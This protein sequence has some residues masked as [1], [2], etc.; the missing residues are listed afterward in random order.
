[1]EVKTDTE[2][3]ERQRAMLTR[4]LLVDQPPPDGG[5]QG[6]DDGG[7]R[8]ARPR[9]P[10]RRRPGRSPARPR[11]RRGLLEPRD[12]GQPRRLH[13]LRPLRAGLRRHP[14][15]RRHRPLGQGLWHAHRLRP[16]RPDGRVL[17]RDVRRVR[18]G[19]PDRGPRQQA[20]QRRADQA[21]LGARLG[22]DASARTAGSA[23][24]SPTTSTA[25]ATRSPSP[26]AA[27]SPATAA[28]CASRAATGGTTPPTRSGSRFRS[29]GAR[30]PTPRARCR[31]TCAAR[32]R[33]GASRAGWWTTRRCCR[34][35]ARRRWEE[36]LD[37]AAGRLKAIH[38]EHGPGAIAG[39]GSAKCSNEE[40]YLFQKL[41]RAGFGTNNV[42]H[43]TRLCHASSVAALFEGVGSGAVSTTYGDIV[44]AEVAIMAGTNTTA[45]HPVASSFFKQARRRGTKLIVVDPRRER[46]AD[47]A[48]IFCQI[49]PGTDVA[50]YNGV[51]HEIIKLGLV[52]REFIAAA[53]DELRRAG[54][55][56]Q[57]VPA[58]ARGADLRGRRRRHPHRREAVGRGEHGD[59]LLG[60]G[61]LAAHDRHRQRP[62]PDR[63]V[64]DH[65][66][67]WPAG[68]RPA[69]AARPEQRPGGLGRRADP[70][71]VPGLSARGPGGGPRDLPGARGA[72]SSIPTA[73]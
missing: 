13:P 20:D 56:G 63:A 26:R 32:A 52:D 55:D 28:G 46:I 16:E 65:R 30:A 53:D 72:A 31:A 47:H 69:P 12:R 67:G 22:R 24:R 60:H 54:Q 2:Q 35:S 9:A 71:D 57:G 48:D 18:R 4:L 58:G 70:D 43:C 8:A 66:P 50:F 61:D 23:A 21:A 3:V 51:M 36:A 44:N 29:S 49:K 19:L 27:S 62:L 40:A 14:G 59:R 17:V 33:G 6:D 68:H 25:S 1:M 34:T 45:N 38:S 10:L 42:D 37:L 39:F 41:I 7:Q 15:Q 73:G 64:L 11:A 5:P